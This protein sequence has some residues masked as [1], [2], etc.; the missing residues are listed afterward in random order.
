[1]E[2]RMTQPIKGVSTVIFKHCECVISEYYEWIINN[3]TSGD[4]L[5]FKKLNEPMVVNNKKRALEV[6]SPH[7]KVH[8]EMW[9]EIYKQIENA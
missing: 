4:P 7:L 2:T 9:Q 5:A 3:P 8:G 6:M 1:M